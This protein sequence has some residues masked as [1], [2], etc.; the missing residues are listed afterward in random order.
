VELD[1]N[2]NFLQLSN[3]L[4][5]NGGA[6]AVSPLGGVSW[7]NNF[8]GETIPLPGAY[9]AFEVTF[10]A[11]DLSGGISATTGYFIIE[12]TVGPQINWDVNGV[13]A[14]GGTTV[15]IDRKDQPGVVQVNPS[16]WSGAALVDLSIVSTTGRV[17]ATVEGN[18][19]LFDRGK[20]GNSI[21]LR[22]QAVDGSGLLTTEF[23]TITID[24]EK[25]P[26]R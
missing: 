8:S 23:L 15:I 26:R 17:I 13:A 21:T 9:Q 14:V 6:V 16:D 1:G 19:V 7:G 24:K 10:Y 11:T 18:T 22:A 20:K 4:E 2:A 12:D 5:S 3:Y 25:K